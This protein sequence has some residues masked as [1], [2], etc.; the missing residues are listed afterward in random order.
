MILIASNSG[1]I[2]YGLKNYVI[3]KKVDLQNLPID[4]PMGSTAFC[5][6]DSSVYMINSSG[7]WVEITGMAPSFS[8]LEWGILGDNK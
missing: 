8:N 3:D 1:N 7:E 4:V 2:A 5:I 6:E